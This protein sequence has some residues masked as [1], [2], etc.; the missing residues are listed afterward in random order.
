MTSSSWRTTC[1]TH[2]QYPY[3]NTHFLILVMARRRHL[4]FN[5]F[6]FAYSHIE[7]RNLKVPSTSV[8]R[9]S[10]VTTSAS[11]GAVAVAASFAPQPPPPPQQQAPA[12]EV[13]TAAAAAAGRRRESRAAGAAR[14]FGYL[15]ASDGSGDEFDSPLEYAPAPTAA[16]PAHYARDKENAAPS[17]PALHHAMH[18]DHCLRY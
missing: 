18:H 16:A 13:P 11:G 6:V 2:S 8:N 12:Q 3:Q 14:L 10:T 4:L 17:A 15:E 5:R 1:E 7:N 9:A